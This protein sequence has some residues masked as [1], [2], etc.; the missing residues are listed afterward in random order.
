VHVDPARSDHLIDTT[1]AEIAVMRNRP[2]PGWLR[3]SSAHLRTR[4]QLVKW[5]DLGTTYVGSLP[6]KR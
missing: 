3:V 2:M 6:A 4:R 1:H 5:V